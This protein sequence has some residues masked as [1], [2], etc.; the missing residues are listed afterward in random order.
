MEK[1]TDRNQIVLMRSTATAAA[2]ATATATATAV[3]LTFSH[4][5]PFLTE[6]HSSIIV[7]D[8]RFLLFISSLPLFLSLSFPFL[9]LLEPEIHLF[10]PPYLYSDLGELIEDAGEINVSPEKQ[11]IAGQDNLEAHAHKY[12]SLYPHRPSHRSYSTH[13]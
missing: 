4:P 12:V 1:P 10:S 13:S 6:M 2:T 5:S 9:T 7:S 3:L 11:Y 8:L